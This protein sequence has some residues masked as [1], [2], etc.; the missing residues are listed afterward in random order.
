M[1]V[2]LRGSRL[3]D[4]AGLL[5]A[6]R[7]LHEPLGVGVDSPAHWGTHRSRTRLGRLG[8]AGSVWLLVQ[9]SSARSRW[10]QRVRCAGWRE[11]NRQKA[12]DAT[13]ELN[14]KARAPA[15]RPI[16]S[17]PLPLSVD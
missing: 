13:T 5:P 2:Q 3:M 7:A 6:M 14:E 4:P 17:G 8:V 15:H 10:R 9:R 16:A 12:V 11:Q 1:L